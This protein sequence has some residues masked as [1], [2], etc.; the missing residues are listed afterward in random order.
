MDMEGIKLGKRDGIRELVG[1]FVGSLVG[2]L[3]G[4]SE[5][6]ADGIN[7]GICVASP[8]DTNASIKP[9]IADCLVSG[10]VFASSLAFRFS[11]RLGST[12]P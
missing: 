1:V 5:G 7:D 3:L 6:W 2:R 8:A 11:S 9:A 12:V 4:L 10:V